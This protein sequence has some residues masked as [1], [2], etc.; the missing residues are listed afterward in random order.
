MRRKNS[1]YHALLQHIPWNG[2][3]QLVDENHGNKPDSRALEAA[4]TLY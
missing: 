1:V 2:F 3:D 4:M